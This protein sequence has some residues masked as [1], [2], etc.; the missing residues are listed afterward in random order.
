MECV[1]YTQE[2]SNFGY[3]VW[4][5]SMWEKEM[6]LNNKVVTVVHPSQTVL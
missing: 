4:V 1:K 2:A 3:Q 6:S 5:Q